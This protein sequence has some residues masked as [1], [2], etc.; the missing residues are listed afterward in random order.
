MIRLTVLIVSLVL[1]LPLGAQMLKLTREQMVEY[2]PENPYSRFPDGRPKVPTSI[3]EK[4][5]GLSAEDCWGVLRNKKFTNQFAGDFKILDPERKMA[6]RVFT[7]VYM[8]YRP[9]LNDLIMAGVRAT[10]FP[11]GGHQ[12]VIDSLQEDDVLVADAW[13]KVPGFVG[14][15]LATYIMVAT[16]KNGGL[17]VD[18]GIRDL[19][20]IHGM[21]T[22]IYYRFAH[23]AAVTNFTL[24]GTNVP[25]QIGEAT[26]MPGDV[27]IGDREGVTFVPPALIE[28]IIERRV[29][30][31]IHDE[32]TKIKLKTGKYKSHQIYGRPRDKELIDEYNVYRE[33]RYKELGIEPPAH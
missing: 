23:P 17:V 14:D 10:G 21:D 27:A 30:I 12:F 28:P 26:V 7:A 5:R 19:Q 15:N 4:A 9:D 8:P 18:G 25:V 1:S 24:I 16:G 2:T 11:S 20:G 33:K 22:Q 32:W 13:G 3:L 29:E 6:G 31:M